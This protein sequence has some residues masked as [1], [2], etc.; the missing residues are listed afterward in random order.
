[1]QVALLASS[2]SSASSLPAALQ[3]LELGHQL[4]GN[5]GEVALRDT[6]G[7]AHVLVDI[8]TNE[9]LLSGMLGIQDH[10]ASEHGANRQCN[11]SPQLLQGGMMG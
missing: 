2:P 6:Q 1:M 9:L 10:V 11:V 7:G 3:L 4:S 8:G 5:V